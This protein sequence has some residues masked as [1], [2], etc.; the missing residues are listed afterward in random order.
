MDD[1]LAE[2][3]ELVDAA[4]SATLLAVETG[5]LGG[6]VARVAGARARRRSCR[7]AE[8]R[9]RPARLCPATTRRPP[10]P[11]QSRRRTAPARRS[12]PSSRSSSGSSTRRSTSCRASPAASIR[13]VLA[14][15]G[16]AAALRS[17]VQSAAIPVTV[18]DEPLR[19]HSETIELAVYFSCLE[20]LQ[21]AAKHAGPRSVGRHHAVRGRRRGSGSGSRT[22]ET[23]F[24]PAHVERG[25]GTVEPGRPARSSRRVDPDRLGPRRWNLH[26]RSHSRL[27]QATPGVGYAP[28]SAGAAGSAGAWSSG[29]LAA[30]RS[31]A[32]PSPSITASA[33]TD[34]HLRICAVGPH[35]TRRVNASAAAP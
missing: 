29:A 17:A 34:C 19:R 27:T 7:A 24:E 13:S 25:A 21:N 18:T 15:H 30:R 14:E 32:T 16:L 5:R 8:D 6:R 28:G 12:C 23:G 4:A 26:R 35:Q 3:P 10:R 9:A 1:A 2:N 22:T 31:A 11:S 20:A 33:S